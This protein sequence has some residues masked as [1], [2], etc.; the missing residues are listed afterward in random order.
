MSKEWIQ[1]KGNTN[2]VLDGEGFYISYNSNPCSS[3]GFFGSDNHSAETALCKDG[4]FFILNG[5]YRKEYS[6][7][8]DKGFDACKEFYDTLKQECRSSWSSDY[9]DEVLAEVSK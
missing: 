9:F 7:R 4:K 8:I 6:E 1:H 5:D 3:L 2:T